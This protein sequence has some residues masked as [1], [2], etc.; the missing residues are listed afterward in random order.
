MQRRCWHTTD[1]WRKNNIFF[2]V[3]YFF[4][5]N[6]A[7]NWCFSLR[8]LLPDIK[9]VTTQLWHHWVDDAEPVHSSPDHTELFKNRQ[10]EIAFSCPPWVLQTAAAFCSEVQSKQTYPERNVPPGQTWRRDEVIGASSAALYLHEFHLLWI[11]W[12]L[13]P[14]KQP[15]SWLHPCTAQDS[16]LS[17]PKGYMNTSAVEERQ[18]EVWVQGPTP[19]R[20]FGGACTVI[21]LL[22]AAPFWLKFWS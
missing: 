5:N 4:H 8:Y 22:Y 19:H 13:S 17:K 16:L 2:S 6:Q 14:G 12:L 1:W 15:Q 9:Y 11:Q 3:L 10:C 7:L 20:S 18:A 21:S